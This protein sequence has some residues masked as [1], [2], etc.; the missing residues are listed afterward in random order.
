M[1]VTDVLLDTGLGDPLIW[2]VPMTWAAP[3]TW[4]G[5]SVGASVLI[6][7]VVLKEKI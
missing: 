3:K 7:D 6:G 5:S 2:V 1:R 4:V